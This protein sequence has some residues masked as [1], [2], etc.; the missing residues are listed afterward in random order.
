[1][2][3]AIHTC[4]HA[5]IGL[6]EFCSGSLTHL[7]TST[8][9]THMLTHSHTY[10]YIIYT[11]FAIIILIILL[12]YMQVSICLHM[13]TQSCVCVCVFICITV[14]RAFGNALAAVK[15][16]GIG[17]LCERENKSA[18]PSF[19]VRVW[20]FMMSCQ[21]HWLIWQLGTHGSRWK[22]LKESENKN[23]VR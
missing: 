8:A 17:Q 23:C 20:F 3:L 12:W 13:C 11:S 16:S 7:H 14:Y 18:L 19:L 21:Q 2:I 10:T 4:M 5:I 15:G 22:L 9:M 1:M 6:G